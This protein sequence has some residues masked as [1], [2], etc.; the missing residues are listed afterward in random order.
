[1]KIE[2][3]NQHDSLYS[4]MFVQKQKLPILREKKQSMMRIVGDINVRYSYSIFIA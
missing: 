1:M 2:S 3:K 4:Y